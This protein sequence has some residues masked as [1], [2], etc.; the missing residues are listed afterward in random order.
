MKNTVFLS[1]I[2]CSLCALAIFNR[3]STD[4]APYAP[5]QTEKAEPV[6]DASGMEQLLLA[7]RGDIET[8][9][10][11]H[12]GLHQLGE[13]TRQIA[14]VQSADRSSG[15]HYWN[16]MGPDNVGGRTRCIL[17]VNEFQ[18]IT[19]GVSGGLWRSWNKGDN[20]ERISSFP[21]AMVASI[22]MA[23]NGDLYVGTGTQFDGVSG[24]GGSG[25]RGDGVYRS[26]DNGETWNRVEGTDP[27]LFNGGDWSATD[28]LVADPS[29]VNRV[30]YGGIQGIGYIENG[31]VTEDAIDGIAGSSTVQD[32]EIAADGSYMLISAGNGRVYR[33]TDFSTANSVSGSQ[34]DPVI[35][36]G[37]GRC[38]VAISPDDSQHAYALLATS[39]SQ[40][41]GVFHSG[42]GGITWEEIWPDGVEGYD[43]CPTNN[44]ARYDLALGVKQGDPEM[45]F[46]GGQAL[47]KCGPSYQAEQAATMYGGAAN[48]FYVHADVHEIIFTPGGTMYVAGDGGIF[49]SENGGATYTACNR[50]LQLTQFYGIAY[51]P[52]SEAIGG[53]QDNGTSLIPG[54]GAFFNDLDAADVFGGDGFDCAI[55]QATGLQEGVPFF[56]TSQNGVLG[57]GFYVQGAPFTQAGD[58]WDECLVDLIADG[59]LTSFYT[60]MS[61]YEDFNDENSGMTVPLVNPFDETIE[62]STFTMETANLNRPFDYTLEAPLRYWDVLIRPEIVSETGPVE[63]TEYPW[64]DDQDL[65]IIYDC[66]DVEVIENGDTSL[67][68]VCDT[69]WTYAADTL[70]D[71]H[72]TIEVTDPYTTMTVMSFSGSSGLWMTRNGLNFNAQPRWFRLGNAPNGGGAKGI[73]FAAGE[74]PEAGNHIFVAGWDAKL[75]RY[76]GLNDLWKHEGECGTVDQVTRTEIMA[77]GA[78]VT[79]VAV[80]VNDPNHVVAT[81]GGYGNVGGGKVQETFNALDADPDWSNIWFASNNDLS[82][83]PIYDVVIDQGD[84]SGQTILVGTEHGVWQTTDGGDTWTVENL[85]MVSNA[86]DVASPVFC[87]EQQ[88]HMPMEWSQVTNNGAIYAGTHGRGIFRSDTYLGTDEDL[89]SEAVDQRN[90]LVYPNPA[91]GEDVTVQLGEGWTQPTLRLFDI[92]G[93]PVRTVSPQ[94]T[95]GGQVRISVGD[96]APGLYIISAEEGRHTESTRVIIR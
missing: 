29:V 1:A 43:I 32:I 69:T 2:V 34:N 59:A 85:G 76:S 72:E 62:D 25:F 54:N 11:N 65:S 90:L 23:G 3:P 42:D 83:M 81:V 5:R 56:A 88:W 78:V 52:T 37:F 30:W 80:D 67:V 21:S 75:Y 7:L 31:V 50:G 92:N 38:R 40:F 44:Q 84:A 70:Y 6:Q 51:G 27:G 26:T 58:F 33:S 77:T 35:Q 24:V 9:E 60:C 94:A 71:V 22:A 68:T 48:P 18:L 87:M 17:A 82:K 86:D 49:R 39:G 10:M 28:A 41:G 4:K 91:E 74:H 19:G 89:F 79:G 15:S 14:A 53:S 12:E 95:A 73:E 16:A 96:L 93:R 66:N 63:N 57:R 46:V 45:A 61:L 64:L 13:R 47:W 8:G 55:S 20:W 36:Q